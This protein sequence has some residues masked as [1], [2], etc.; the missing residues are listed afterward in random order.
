[1]LPERLTAEMGENVPLVITSDFNRLKEANLILG[2]SN[3]P[4]AVIF[5]EML[6]EVPLVICDISVPMDTHPSVYKMPD[7]TVIQG[8][9]VRLPLNPDFTIRGL[10][11]EKG[12]AFAC[13]GETMLLGLTGISED[14]SY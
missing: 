13:M 1:D 8:G 2:G 6:Q 3:A 10:P 4:G 12:T 5:P 11:L 9:L 14:Y 7:V